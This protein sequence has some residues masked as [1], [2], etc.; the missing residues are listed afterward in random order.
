[1]FVYLSGSEKGKTRIFTQDRVSLGTSE[2]FDVKLVPEEGGSLPDGEIADVYDDGGVFYLIRRGADSVEITVNGDPIGSN[3]HPL[4]DGDT[5]HFG[6]G[7]S[8]ASLLFQIL[9]ATFG[10]T[11]PV[12]RA[13]G[14]LEQQ[15]Q[16]VHPLTATLFVKEL[17]ASL[18]AE[19]PRRPKLL[20]LTMLGFLVSLIVGAVIYNFIALHRNNRQVG[21][22]QEQ[23]TAEAARRQEDQTFIK[24]QQQEIERLRQMSEQTR[25]FAQN[26]SERYSHGVCLIVGSYSFVERGT[27]R[28][29]RY[30]SADKENDNPVDQHGNLLVSVNGAGPAVQI[31]W[32]GTGFV[33]EEGVIVTNKHVVQPTAGDPLAQIIIRQGSAQPRL[34][35]L[36]AF[37]PSIKT[38][39]ELKVERVSD[40]YDLALCTFA[41]GNAA[42]PVL[43]VSGEDIKSIIG[44]PVVLLGYPTGVDGLLQRIDESERKAIM[45]EHGRSA[46]D[47]AMGLA[48]KALVRPLTT[49]GVISDALPGRVVHSA[50]TTEGGSGGPLFDREG[51]VIAVNHAVLTAIDGS[52]SFGGSNFGV[53]IK[54][55][56]EF[57]I[58]YHQSK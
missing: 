56:S 9:P 34:D 55:V 5:L 52:Q 58:A 37:F 42:L 19:I 2:S 8:S 29:L 13:A 1:M 20:V 38:P 28:H 27:G 35:T 16:P 36:L 31:E 4:S 44:E 6:H 49:T 50:H 14:Q 32:T 22:L 30:E 24:S 12:P 10:A 40:R 57:L 47:V 53:P 26:I 3:G 39:F 33:V 54:A 46:E 48:E 7:L 25:L 17:A 51:R 18:W 45:S 41:Q 15:A 43:P 23:L 11:H 21:R